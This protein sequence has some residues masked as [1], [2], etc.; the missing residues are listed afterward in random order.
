MID[1]GVLFG[2]GIS[3]PPRVSPDGRMVWSEG[4]QNV[5]EAIRIILLTQQKERLRLPDFGGSLSNF[6][7]EPNT[8]ATRHQI[9]DR[10]NRA[11]GKWE[12]RI[13]VDSVD[14]VADPADTES[15][16]AT[17]SYRLVATQVPQR[18]NV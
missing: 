11:L 5:R 6:L 16:I 3:F 14:V 13:Q 17:I 10:I 1:A 18:M 8:V 9:E 12:P 2:R 4:E 15:A 7:F